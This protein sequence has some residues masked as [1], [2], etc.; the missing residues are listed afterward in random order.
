M[1]K[2]LLAPLPGLF[3]RRPSPEEAPFKQEGEAVAAGETIGLIEA[4]KSF[5]PVEAETA[6]KLAR[7]LVQDG[8][9]VDADQA[10]AEM[11]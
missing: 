4:M 6:G 1:A 2:Q 3:Y 11:D 10:I 9:T 8:E 7:F 5:F